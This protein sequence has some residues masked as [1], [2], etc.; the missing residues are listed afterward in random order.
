MIEHVWTVL[1]ARSII[2]QSSNN[3]SLLD[4]IEQINVQAPPLQEGQEGMLPIHGELVTL[5]TRSAEN[6]PCRGDARVR[7]V[8][9][10][11]TTMHEKD[12]SVDLMVSERT[13]TK[14][15]IPVLAVRE[16]GRHHFSVLL[17]NEN[18]TEWHPV[19]TVPFVITLVSVERAT[20]PT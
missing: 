20:P 9:P 17:R 19:A 6:Q 3:I 14:I 2:D 5:W 4:I 10:S 13:R 11:G 1:C 18:D 12:Y 7:L 16:L 15:N 8:G